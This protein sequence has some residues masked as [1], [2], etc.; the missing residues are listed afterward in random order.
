MR[1]Q[2]GMAHRR[3]PDTGPNGLSSKVLLLVML[4]IIVLAVLAFLVLKPNPSGAP[5][6]KPATRQQ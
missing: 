2:V 3:T 5:T 6:D 4:G 1:I